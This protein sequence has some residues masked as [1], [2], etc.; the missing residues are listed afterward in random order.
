MLLSAP[1][2]NDSKNH[3]ALTSY[4]DIN[5]LTNCDQSKWYYRCARLWPLSTQWPWPWPNKVI[6]ANFMTLTK[7]SDI[8]HLHDLDQTKW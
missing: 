7:Q 6:L 4:G 8:S 1:L 2:F 5:P 3:F